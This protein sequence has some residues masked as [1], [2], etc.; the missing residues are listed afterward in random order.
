MKNYILSIAILLNIIACSEHK[1]NNT[2]AK[3][4]ELETN[5]DYQQALSTIDK[6]LQK[7]TGNPMLY[8]KRSELHVL[9][10]NATNALDDLSTAISL[11]NESQKTEAESNLFNIHTTLANLHYARAIILFDADSLDAALFDFEYCILNNIHTEECLQQ[12]ELIYSII[13]DSPSSYAATIKSIRNNYNKAQTENEISTLVNNGIIFSN[14][15]DDVWFKGPVWLVTEKQYDA[16]GSLHEKRKIDSSS[17]TTL[18]YEFYNNTQLK[19]NF[20]SIKNTGMLEYYFYKYNTSNINKTGFTISGN[21]L[22]KAASGT[23]HFDKKNRIIQ[24]EMFY[25]D[26]SKISCQEFFKYNQNNFL[27]KRWLNC[28]T[29]TT[30]FEYNNQGQITKEYK[31]GE[32]AISFSVSYT[33]K[34]NSTYIDIANNNFEHLSVYTYDKYNNWVKQEVFKNRIL[35]AVIVREIIYVE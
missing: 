15:S 20:A 31:K 2:V 4:T 5:G 7:D 6:L 17:Y 23:Y 33:F 16:Y 30:I 14:I 27:S 25:P 21:G 35:T 19:H 13:T 11:L 28:D 10:N 32:Q 24:R 8:H 9:N 22:E 1:L 29:D 34:G 3:I 12:R 26:G 18:I